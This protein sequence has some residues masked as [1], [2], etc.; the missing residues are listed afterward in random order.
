[1]MGRPRAHTALLRFCR[2]D[3]GT[4]RDAAEDAFRLLPS[5]CQDGELL[6]RDR[7]IS[8]HVPTEMYKNHYYV[9]PQEV[10]FNLK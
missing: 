4:I 3:T 10:S 8:R 5:R 9:V 2:P 7:L 1:M 6:L